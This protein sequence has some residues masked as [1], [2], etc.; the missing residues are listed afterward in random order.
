M[1]SINLKDEVVTEVALSDTFVY[2]SFNKNAELSTIL[3][4]AVKDSIII[5]ENYIDEQLLTIKRIKLSPIQDD[6]ISAFLEG[7]LVILYSN[8]KKVPSIIPFF[9]IR[10]GSKIRTYIFMNNFGKLVTDKT[11]LN[12]KYLDIPAKNL[13]ALMEGAYISYQYTLYPHK[14]VRSIGLMRPCLDTYVSMVMRILNKEYALSMDMEAYDKVSFA[15]ARFFI[16]TVW[17]LTNGE[18]I[19]SYARQN[20]TIK[21]PHATYLGLI[22][23]EF[24]EKDIR[25]I[26]QLIDFIKTLTPRLAALSPRYFYQRWIETYK[27][28]TSF[29][30]E[31]LPYFMYVMTCTIIGSF[32]INSPLIADISKDVKGIRNY[33]AELE[34]VL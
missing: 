5:N 30:L 24:E 16:E 20:K 18:Q 13:Y 17:G 23:D 15:V 32:L 33:Y 10:S 34:K 3:T 9:T 22:N 26:D 1:A 31:S 21:D 2:K 6:V 25:S 12:H 19:F 7:N 4:A 27:Y 8:V 28:S 14:L 11:D 29:S